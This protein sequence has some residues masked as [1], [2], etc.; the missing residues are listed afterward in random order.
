[1]ESQGR[2]GGARLLGLDCSGLGAARVGSALP[3][4]GERAT[5][6]ARLL[7]AFAL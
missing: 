1:M 5:P 6:T 3:Y 7:P 2:R 4:G